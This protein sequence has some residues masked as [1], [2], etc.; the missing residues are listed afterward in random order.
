MRE[1]FMG[2]AV[3]GLFAFAFFVAARIGGFLE[4]NY[5]GA[6]IQQNKDR[7]VTV[8]FG[9]SAARTADQIRKLGSD[10]DRCAVIV[11]D[12]E[13]SDI[14][15]YFDPDWCVEDFRYKIV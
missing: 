12:A 5:Q 7:S 10:C 8:A 2:L 15:D 9:D 13:D 4:A 14:L 3:L 1:L 11:C 6:D